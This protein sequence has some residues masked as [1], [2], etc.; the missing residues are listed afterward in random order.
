MAT[1]TG[2]AV[3]EGCVEELSSRDEGE[4][5]QVGEVG[6][7]DTGEGGSQQGMCARGGKADGRAL[8]VFRVN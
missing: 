7:E 3:C 6:V 1:T 5:E 8:A 4:E 2:D